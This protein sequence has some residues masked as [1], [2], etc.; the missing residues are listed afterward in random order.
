MFRLLASVIALI[1]AS[2]ALHAADVEPHTVVVKWRAQAPSLIQWNQTGRRGPVSSLTEIIGSHT[3]EPY[4]LDATLVSVARAQS[5]QQAKTTRPRSESSI[6]RISIVR[7]DADIDPT[8]LARKISSM[9]DVE[10]AEPLSQHH[11]VEIPNDPEVSLQYHLGLIRAFDA[12]ELLPTDTTVVVGIVD[13]G[14]DTAHVDLGANVWRNSGETGFD[15]NNVDKRFNKIDDDANGFVD[16][17]FGWDFVGANGTTPDNT[18]LPGNLHG[19]HVGGIAAAV[20]NNATGVAGVGKNIRLMAVKIGRDDPSSISVARTA[21]AILYA[22]SMGASVVNCSFGSASFS[23]ADDEIIQMATQLGALI[24]AAAGNDGVDMAFYPAGYKNVMSVAATDSSDEIAYFSNTH[25]SVDVCAPGVG[26]YSTIPNDLYQYLDGTSMASPVAAAVAAMV[27]LRNPTYSPAELRAAV[28]AACDNIDE[29]NGIFVGRYGNGRVNAF[30]AVS[31]TDPQWVEVIGSTFI[32]DDGNGFYEAGD[33]LHLTLTLR[34]E[35]S[36]LRNAWI[37]VVPAPA[38]FSPMIVNDSIKI[39]PLQHGE[40]RTL[41]EDVVI[42]LPSDIPF[43]GELRLMVRIF[44]S[45]QLVSR[46]IIT[47][48][49]NPTF[50]TLAVNDITTTI[51]SMGNIGFNDYP[52]NLQGMGFTYKGSPNLLFEGALMIGVGPRNLPN[53]ARGGF[54]EAKDTSFYPRIVTQL[55]VDSIPTG[56]RVVTRFSDVYDPYSVG[57]DVTQNVYAMTGDSLRNT[58]IVALDIVNR[59]DTTIQDLYVGQ[60]YDFDIGPSGANNGCAWDTKQGIGL[61]QNAKRPD[62]PSIGVSMISP[63]ATNFYAVDNDGDEFGIEIY[64][65]FLRAEKWQLMSGG[66]RRK[67]SRIT[68][69]STSISAGPFSLAPGERQQVCFVIAAGDD[70]SYITKGVTAA[71]RAAQNMGL[72][73][74]PYS[75]I[76]EKNT[77]IYLEGAPLVGL[78][79][80]EIRFSVGQPTPV[81]IDIVDLFGSTVA[82]VVDEPNVAVGTYSRAI[83]IPSVAQGTYFLRMTTYLTPSIFSFGIVR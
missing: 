79:T 54:T 21:D 67:N 34:N 73:A 32:D 24:V 23:S 26:I 33:K 74:V 30:A 31:A 35:L 9:P 66:I 50:R 3:S 76:P 28:M 63:L 71:R 82:T 72:N 6:S 16:D 15:A 37:R 56:A 70:Y 29:K 57:V 77:I 40:I 55:R 53:V 64:N 19:T 49:V 62:L 65:N 22:A 13:T 5:K 8:L 17:W 75:E 1:V 7:Y 14:I 80:R 60:F 46:A 27:R 78:G 42:D 47:T 68:D 12:W 51:N 4:V 45:T 81:V 83:T 41:T 25:S 44:D 38:A 48:I 61:I 69:V 39:G 2:T 43:N 52:A 11:I 20:V 58:V 59:V 36:A 10:Y 18:P